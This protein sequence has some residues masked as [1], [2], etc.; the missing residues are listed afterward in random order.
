MMIRFERIE[1]EEMFHVSCAVDNAT[2]LDTAGDL[3]VEDD[4]LFE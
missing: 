2:N 4:V 1:L 3:F